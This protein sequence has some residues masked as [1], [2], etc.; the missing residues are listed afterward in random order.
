MEARYPDQNPPPVGALTRHFGGYCCYKFLLSFL[1][2][3]HYATD[4]VIIIR[5][6]N[7]GSVRI[8]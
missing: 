2:V 3:W 4:V 8:V 6:H 1:I 7:S 5:Y